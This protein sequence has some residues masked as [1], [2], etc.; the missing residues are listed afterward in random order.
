[1][2]RV[3]KL[4]ILLILITIYKCGDGIRQEDEFCD[5]GGVNPG[6]INCVVTKDYVCTGLSPDVCT[7]L[8]NTCGDGKKKS[9]EGCDDG[10]A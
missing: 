4:Y 5:T 1:M 3:K 6:C 9:T 2:K 7:L 8:P 10:N